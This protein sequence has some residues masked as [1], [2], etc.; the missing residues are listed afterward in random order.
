MNMNRISK[1]EMTALLQICK[2]WSPYPEKKAPQKIFI[3]KPL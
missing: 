3:N 2:N 1:L